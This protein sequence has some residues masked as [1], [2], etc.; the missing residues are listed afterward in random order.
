[1]FQGMR[2]PGSSCTS[3]LCLSLEFTRW[4][5]AP[6]LTLLAGAYIG[7]SSPGQLELFSGMLN[8][9]ENHQ[10]YFW[11]DSYQFMHCSKLPLYLIV[12]SW[13]ISESIVDNK[14]ILRSRIHLKL[15]EKSFPTKLGVLSLILVD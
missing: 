7:F 13:K 9:F 3:R 2:C 10:F 11:T 5:N 6:K 12:N 4:L 8:I 14:E 15:V 1:M